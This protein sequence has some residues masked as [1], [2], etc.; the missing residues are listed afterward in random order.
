MAFSFRAIVNVYQDH[1]VVLDVSLVIVLSMEI[2]FVNVDKM[3]SGLDIN[4]NVKVRLF[5]EIIDGRLSFSE[6]RCPS[7]KIHPRVQQE[8]LP[9]QNNNKFHFGTKCQAKCNATGYRLVGPRVRE[10]LSTG[11]WTGYEQFCIGK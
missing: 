10:C 7:L 11:E 8:C 9:A 4:Q 2:V 5:V 6:I 1:Y 3:G